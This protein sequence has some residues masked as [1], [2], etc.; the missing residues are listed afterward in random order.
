MIIIIFLEF[1]SLRLI[2]EDSKITATAILGIGI[3]LAIFS[4]VGLLFQKGIKINI[5]DRLLIL[6]VISM[7]LSSFM[8]NL[9]YDQSFFGSI[10]AYKHFY[11]YF[12]YFS[13]LIFKIE[14]KRIKKIV[15]IFYFITLLIFLTE[16]IV[17]PNSI[18]SW[19]SEE[20]R[21]GIS[22]F[23]YGQ[24]FTFLG[25]FY[26]LQRFFNKREILPLILFSLSFISLFFLTLSRMNLLALIIG[27]F[28]ILYFSNFNRK[29]LFG[30]GVLLL[31]FLLFFFSTSFN[32]IKNE[33]ASQAQVIRE[34]IRFTAQKHFLFELQGGVLT[35]MFGNGFPGGD[36]KLQSQ[37]TYANS[38]G[39]YT[40]DIGLTGIYS[41]FGIFGLLIWIFLFFSVFRIPNE[42]NILFLKAYFLALLTTV[43]TG[44]SIFEPGYMP[45]TILTFYLVRSHIYKKK[46]LNIRSLSKSKFY[47]V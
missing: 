35:H 44:Y 43:F 37:S 19:R 4:V 5:I 6:F 45:A 20:R 2:T 3:S 28:Y 10:K 32:S 15:I 25:A 8:A 13:L 18:F 24:G 11:I 26:F 17:F 12:L 9:F 16:Y 33:S 27:I 23:F 38:K 46:L 34:D 42:N 41:Y 7:F 30:F 29:F 40:A 36:S 47:Y 31:G 22:I 39:L 14:P 1:F 21:G